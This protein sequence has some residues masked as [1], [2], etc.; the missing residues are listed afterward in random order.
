MANGEATLRSRDWLAYLSFFFFQAEDGIRD[1]AVTGVQTCALPIFIEAQRIRLRRSDRPQR[2]DGGPRR[3]VPPPIR[4]VES[5]A[6]HLDVIILAV[7]RT[8]WGEHHAGDFHARQRALRPRPPHPP[9]RQYGG[10]VAPRRPAHLKR[11]RGAA[12]D[13]A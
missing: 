2:Q 6:A 13:R 12:P 7:G 8:S 3:I 11:E 5:D 4:H 9:P 10:R 1:V